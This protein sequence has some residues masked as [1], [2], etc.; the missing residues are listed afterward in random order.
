MNILCIDPGPTTS[1]VV[2]LKTGRLWPPRVIPVGAKVPNSTVLQRCSLASGLDLLV[3]ERIASYG[4][5]VG[6][7]VFETV[8]WAAFFELTF[9][10]D[11]TRRLSRQAVKM[12]ICKS[13]RANDATIRQA[14]IDL[15]GGPDCIKGA[16]A[17]TRKDPGRQAGE[18]SGI[19][20]DAW[21][22]L[23]V[24]LTHLIHGM[25]AKGVA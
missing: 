4:M 8:R 2:Q 25:N 1:G 13:P 6:E 3:I 16:K 5:P 21:S 14:L 11:R 19:R 17:A 22:A 9:G 24:G 18:L 20:A 10:P 12:A 15:Y 7:E 23:A